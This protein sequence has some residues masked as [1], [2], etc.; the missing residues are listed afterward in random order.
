M[1]D[2]ERRWQEGLG[3]SAR[4]WYSPR[5]DPS[6]PQEREKMEHTGARTGGQR[7]VLSSACF[8][9]PWDTGSRVSS[10]TKDRGG[11][12]GF[13]ERRESWEVTENGRM[14]KADRKAA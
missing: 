14:A 2:K 12:S 11:V 13:Q 4:W 3:S 1:W 8:C 6:H 5:W 10:E 7:R 9:F